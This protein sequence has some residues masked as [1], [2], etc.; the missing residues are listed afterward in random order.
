[1]LLTSDSAAPQVTTAFFS[2]VFSVF[3]VSATVSSST[4]ATYSAAPPPQ[5]DK[6]N[7]AKNNMAID[8]N[9]DTTE[10]DMTPPKNLTF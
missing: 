2:S 3:S 7:S 10:N 4:G 5:A 6:T 9:V 8:L 1:M